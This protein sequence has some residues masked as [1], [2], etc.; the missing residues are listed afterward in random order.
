MEPEFIPRSVWFQ[1]PYVIPPHNLSAQ[2]FSNWQNFVKRMNI[3][4]TCSSPLSP[5]PPPL[6]KG[7]KWK[8][9][10]TY[11]KQRHMSEEKGK[12]GRTSFNYRL[13]GLIQEDSRN[14]PWTLVSGETYS[15]RQKAN[16]KKQLP[17]IWGLF[18]NMLLLHLSAEGQ[19]L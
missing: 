14:S 8:H 1:S 19:V 16:R 15:R 5:F 4:T 13:N 2:A 3:E 11:W 18:D 6:S 10:Q 12:P 7:Q 9:P 17:S